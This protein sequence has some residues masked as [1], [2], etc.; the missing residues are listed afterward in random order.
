MI[1][2]GF[3]DYDRWK[4]ATPPEYEWADGEEDELQTC[5]C[6][7]RFGGV[8]DPIIYPEDLFDLTGGARG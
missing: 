3:G 2:Y 8:C 1:I 4:L 6:C 5:P 7:G